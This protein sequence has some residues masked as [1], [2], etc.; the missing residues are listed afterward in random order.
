MH[1]SMHSR[2]AN[3]LMPCMPAT[4]LLVLPHQR[5]ATDQAFAFL[6]HEWHIIGKVF[7]P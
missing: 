3:A 7:E 2:L 4:L 1:H 6:K 5:V